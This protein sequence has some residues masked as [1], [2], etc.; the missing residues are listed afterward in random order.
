MPNIGRAA[1]YRGRVSPLA[2]FSSYFARFL[3]VLKRY[4]GIKVIQG[5]SRSFLR[6]PYRSP[7]SSTLT[8]VI[9]ISMSGFHISFST[10]HAAT[11][12]M[13]IYHGGGDDGYTPMVA[14][15]IVSLHT[16]QQI[17]QAWIL[18]LLG[19]CCRFFI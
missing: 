8:D 7:P 9:A 15:Y 19:D 4:T 14:H 2:Y 13:A 6:M 10:Y 18:Q 3:L 5:A 16:M 17:P 12:G 1:I 11:H